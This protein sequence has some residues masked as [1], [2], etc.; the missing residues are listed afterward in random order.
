MLLWLILRLLSEMDCYLDRSFCSV[1]L[2]V[3]SGCVRSFWV[4]TSWF[5]FVFSVVNE[6]Q[7]VSVGS[8][9]IRL[10]FKIQVG[11][12]LLLRCLAT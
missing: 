10:F 1:S 11:K 2:Y 3:V 8:N 4:V 7:K 6:V 12:V 9:C 5:G